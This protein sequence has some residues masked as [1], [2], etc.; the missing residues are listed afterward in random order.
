MKFNEAVVG[1]EFYRKGLSQNLTHAEKYC[2][3]KNNGY[4]FDGAACT[5]SPSQ[6]RYSE[7]SGPYKAP[8]LPTQPNQCSG[9]SNDLDE[10][11]Y[12]NHRFQ[13]RSTII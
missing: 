4:S 2:W 5:A 8:K 12:C 3:Q 10:T 1:C 11:Q 13:W 7:N 6:L 9:E